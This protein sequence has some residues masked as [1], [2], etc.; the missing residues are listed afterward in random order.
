MNLAELTSMG[1]QVRIDGDT[2]KIRPKEK[3]TRELLDRIAAA[4]PALILELRICASVASFA[5][6]CRI[7][8]VRPSSSASRGASAKTS[9]DVTFPVLSICSRAA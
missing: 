7:N 9:A 3:L 6:R 2:L 4:K 8:I 1:F 5:G